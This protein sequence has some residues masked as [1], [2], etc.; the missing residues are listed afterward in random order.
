MVSARSSTLTVVT[1]VDD[2]RRSRLHVVFLAGDHAL[3]A[4]A[5]AGDRSPWPLG[6]PRLKLLPDAPSAMRAG[7]AGLSFSI[8]PHQARYVPLAERP[9]EDIALRE[10]I[11]MPANNF[12]LIFDNA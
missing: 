1:G 5:E 2:P 10:I 4:I 8:A 11:A 7:I 9:A 3:L 12:I 6:I